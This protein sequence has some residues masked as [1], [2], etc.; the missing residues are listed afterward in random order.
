MRPSDRTIRDELRRE[1]A[2]VSIPEDMWQNIS[3]Q[4][5][6]KTVRQ[7]MRRRVLGWTEQWRPAV[8][9]A[10]AAGFFWFAL[11]PA[12]PSMENMPGNTNQTSITIPSGT[13]EQ[14]SSTSTKQAPQDSDAGASTNN[15]TTAS[16]NAPRHLPALPQ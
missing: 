14:S 3:R 11:I 1:A 12:L 13:T 7:E 4:L 2:K 15:S 10:V 6:Q 8:I 9:L 16:A 5:D